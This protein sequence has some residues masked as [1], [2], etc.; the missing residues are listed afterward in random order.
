MLNGEGAKSKFVS[1][2]IGSDYDIVEIFRTVIK[3]APYGDYASIAQYKI[4]LYLQGKQMYQEAR[5]EFEKVI[6]D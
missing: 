1:T 2:V 4:G 6:N 5:D 3:N